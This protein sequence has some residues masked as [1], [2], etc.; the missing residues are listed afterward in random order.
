MV[1][2]HR[3]IV[4]ICLSM[5]ILGASVCPSL[6]GDNRGGGD[7]SSSASPGSVRNSIQS[8]PSGERM[9]WLSQLHQNSSGGLGSGLEGAPSGNAPSGGAAIANFQ[10]LIQLIE[11]TIEADWA[12]NGGTATIMEFRQGVSLDPNGVIKRLSA[13]EMKRPPKLGGKPVDEEQARAPAITLEQLGVWQQPTALRWVSLSQLDE[14][15]RQRR[16]SGARASVAMELLGGL[17]RLDYLAYDSVRDEWF[18]GGPAGDLGMNL[19]GE[20]LNRDSLLPPLLLEDLLCV[21]PHVLGHRGELG[22]SIDPVPERLTAAYEMAQA[23]STARELQNNP[24]KWTEKWRATLGRQKATI[25]GIPADSPTGYA[26]L[27]ADAHMKRV[28]LGLEHPAAKMKNY[29]QEAESLGVATNQGMLRWWFSLND[30]PILVDNE[31]MIYNFAGSN[32]Q[33]LSETQLFNQRGDRVVANTPDL[34]ADAFAR[35]FTNN[36]TKLQK[37]YP[38]YGRLRH[39]FDLA[40][41]LEIVRDQM[42]K[43]KGKPFSVLADPAITP[44]LPV[45]PQELDSVAATRKLPNGSVTAIIS[46]G[47]SINPR[48]L[49]KR[50]QSDITGLR[51]VAL[52]GSAGE[53]LAAQDL[54]HGDGITSP[55]SDEVFWK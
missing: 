46:G 53:Q 48:Q 26:L 5:C 1:L 44:K 24:E 45:A 13:K 12:S 41:A 22:C 4:A 50:M 11:T 27:V 17:Y 43:G 29:W 9:Q 23:R 6:A 16:D 42:S 34:A 21:G 52:E 2:T 47:V 7:S 31:R 19:Y 55:K 37:L 10:S 20:I 15:I 38:E 35:G 40:V 36:F 25:V 51:R 54:P 18:L 49:S 3:S 28:G 32:V 8:L 30:S 39:I 14:Q 33:V